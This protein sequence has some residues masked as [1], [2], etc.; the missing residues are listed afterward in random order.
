MVDGHVHIHGRFDL[1]TFL[2]NAW[3]NFD[4]AAR[5][6]TGTA[7][8][9]GCLMLSE[10]RNADAF[11]RLCRA[12]GSC[13]GG[14]RI[15]ATHEALSLRLH[16]DGACILLIAGRQIATA[17]GLEVLALGCERR[18]E[19]GRPIEESIEQSVTA[20]AVTVLPWGFGK[21]SF[22][23]R[24]LVER[25][26]HAPGSQTIWLGD[27]AGRLRY[28]PRPRLFEIAARQE[29]GVLPGSDPLP[30]SWHVRRAGRCGFMMP[31]DLDRNRPAAAIHH[32]LRHRRHQPPVYGRY[33]GLAALIRDQAAIRLPQ[34]GEGAP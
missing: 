1:P 22:H 32:H 19:D 4:Q 28:A 27:N 30:L 7:P 16:R 10:S 5:R 18:F 31:A 34:Q 9:A 26:L 25:T 14:W 15:D 12:A 21:W 8:A 6:I 29:I 11:G 20:G 2:N 33:A 3:A 24:R 23:R 17:E 13:F